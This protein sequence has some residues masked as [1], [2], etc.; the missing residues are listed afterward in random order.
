MPAFT[1]LQRS[2]G[3]IVENGLLNTESRS[4]RQTRA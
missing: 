4:R 1:D 2:Y 3:L